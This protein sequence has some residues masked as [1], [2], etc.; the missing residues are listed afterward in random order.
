MIL[1]F[2]N[3]NWLEG[4][5]H[6]RRELS[7]TIVVP[8]VILAWLPVILAWLPIVLAWLPIILAWPL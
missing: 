5:H 1:D 4:S 2:P 8:S 6:G 3:L 7:L